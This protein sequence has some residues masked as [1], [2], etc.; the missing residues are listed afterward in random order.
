MG[1]KLIPGRR[2][3][4]YSCSLLLILAFGVSCQ[5]TYSVGPASST[6]GGG[7][8]TPTSTPNYCQ[9]LTPVPGAY[10]TGI[11]WGQAFLATSNYYGT[12]YNIADVYLLVNGSPETTAAVSVIGPGST[13]PL[14]YYGIQSLNGVNYALYQST[15]IPYQ[16]GASWTLKTV[17][18]IGTAY[19]TMNTPGGGTTASDGSQV[20]WTYP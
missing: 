13:S 18:S 12:V 4:L 16:A 2:A 7:S 6:S 5:K 20:S 11:Y 1:L 9:T 15:T 14:P 3:I 10:S 19:A 8:G 17:T